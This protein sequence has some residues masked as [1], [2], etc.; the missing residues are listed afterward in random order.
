MQYTR[1]NGYFS[2]ALYCITSRKVDCG[3]SRIYYGLLLLLIL[4]STSLAD[5][6]VYSNENSKLFKSSEFAALGEA[7]QVF[8]TEPLPMTNPA[9]VV[10]AKTNRAHL[11]YSSYY[12]NIFNVTSTYMS[13]Q[14]DDIQSAGFSYSY[15]FVPDIDSIWAEVDEDGDP[16][17]YDIRLKTGSEVYANFVYSRKLWDLDFA[18]ITA[19]AALHAKRVRLIDWTGYG[20]GLD[21]GISAMFQNGFATSLQI[22]DVTTEYTYWSK[23][24]SE[25]GL[26]RCYLGLGYENSFGRNRLSLMYRSPD[27]FSNS[28]V[29]Q[30]I[31]TGE[32]DEPE[33]LR[34]R[35]DFSLLYKAAAYGTALTLR[36]IVTFRAGWADTQ[37]LTFGGGVLLYQKLH[38]DF[39][40]A[41][42]KDLAGTYG[43]STTFDF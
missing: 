24:Y 21:I 37:K 6:S 42:H 32:D 26:Q 5:N 11:S 2:R 39:S 28:G 10:R 33:R 22:N 40:Y 17:E 19:G 27:L 35:S 34:V 18:T 36:D 9:N 16:L 31:G 15:L 30:V 7:S 1:V 14:I 8:S 23:N 13:M 29:G 20:I 3:M 41:T 12:Q 25:N 43:V 38:L 4:I